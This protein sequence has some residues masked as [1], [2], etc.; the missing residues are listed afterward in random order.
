MSAKFIR[1]LAMILPCLLLAALF[2]SRVSYAG[3]VDL[4]LITDPPTTAFVGVP[5]AGGFS[6]TSTRSGAGTWHLFAL[7]DADGSFGIAQ[8]KAQL[9]GTLPAI[10]NRLTQTLYDTVDDVG[11][12]AGFT[13]LRS[14]T[15]A[16]PITGSAELPGTQPYT[17]GGLGRTS[18]N[19]STIPGATSFSG[20]TNGQWGNYADPGTSGTTILG[21][22]RNALFVAEGTYTGAAPIVDLANSFVAYYT[23]AQYTN[24]LQATRF[25]ANPLI[26][27][28]PF[29][30][31][32]FSC[33]L[34]V[35]DATIDNVNANSP[36]TLTHT[37]AYSAT[38]PNPGIPLT[39]SNFQFNSFVPDPGSSGTGPAI[40]ATFDP[41]LHKFSWSTLNSP[42]GVYTWQV[43]ASGQG[44]SDTGI[45]HVHITQV[46]EPATLSFAGL[47]ILGFNVLIC[48]R[49]P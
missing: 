29:F 46:P 23:N 28:A 42:R 26:T 18:G 44:Y 47:A 9:I 36:G 37:F 49:R 32:T 1:T 38:L 10:N 48:P 24:S 41:A 45:L 22:A 13:L 16:N 35:S 14:A 39:W 17:Q 40:P 20:T 12:K 2:A 3:S 4:F 8:V 43:T 30:Y 21:H 27:T 19:Y 7:D 25:S 31:C 5:P 6:G 33:D 34:D 11:F 15:N